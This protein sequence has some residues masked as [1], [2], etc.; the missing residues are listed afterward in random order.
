MHYVH[1]GV[2]I[3]R[4]PSETFL[5]YRQWTYIVLLI[6]CVYVTLSYLGKYALDKTLNKYMSSNYMLSNGWDGK[7]LNSMDFLTLK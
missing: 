5:T 4:N 6:F 2:Q 3:A 1:N 7:W